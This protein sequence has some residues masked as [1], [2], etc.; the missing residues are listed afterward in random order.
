V[1]LASFTDQTVVN[2]RKAI[3][4]GLVALAA[5]ALPGQVRAQ[6]KTQ[7]DDSFVVLLK[8]LYQPVTQG[9]NL[10][11]SKVDLNDGSY[12]TTRIYPVNGTPGNTNPAKPVGDF[13][14]QFN[15]DLCAYHIPGGSFSM[16]FTGEQDLVFVDDG[17]GGQFLEGTA[18]LTILE[19]TG[20]YKPFAGGRNHM[21]D[22]LHFLAP[23]DGSGGLDEYCFCFI[24]RQ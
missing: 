15:G 11:L 19:G 3:G 20:V 6:T 14:V 8:G 4:G 1:D 2:R 16:R 24:T 17:Q 18:E 7:P 10:G 13:Y 23:G 5:L 12:S 22:K 21:V 9:P